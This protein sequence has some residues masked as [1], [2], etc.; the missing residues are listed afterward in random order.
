MPLAGGTCHTRV[1][2]WL[3]N[4]HQLSVMIASKG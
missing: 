4:T 1:R 2:N 3:R